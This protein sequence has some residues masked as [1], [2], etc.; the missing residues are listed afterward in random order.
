MQ[1]IRS[2]LPAGTFGA[3]TLFC[4]ANTDAAASEN[5]TAT[6]ST[7]IPQTTCA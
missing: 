6:A 3:G 2:R 7:A 5:P 4:A 1:S